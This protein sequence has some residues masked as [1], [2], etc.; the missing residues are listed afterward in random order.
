MAQKEVATSSKN[1]RSSAHPGPFFK[2]RLVDPEEQLHLDLPSAPA[3]TGLR[4]SK[5]ATRSPSFVKDPPLL[6]IHSHTLP[7][8]SA[9][10]FLSP[11]RSS[12]S[13]EAR[14]CHFSDRARSSSASPDLSR[15]PRS[16]GAPRRGSKGTPCGDPVAAFDCP[17]VVARVREPRLRIDM[18]PREDPKDRVRSTE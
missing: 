9:A 5:H 17:A 4:S 10:K 12:S 15:H 2:C 7:V 13:L 3:W 6:T 1:L 16:A 11:L 18:R 8:S 14:N